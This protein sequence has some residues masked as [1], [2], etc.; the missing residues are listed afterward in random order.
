MLVPRYV[1]AGI[2]TEVCIFGL[3][4]GNGLLGVPFVISLEIVG[5]VF[6][7]LSCGRDN[8]YSALRFIVK[9]AVVV[10]N[11]WPLR[12]GTGLEESFVSMASLAVLVTGVIGFVASPPIELRTELRNY[13]DS[14]AK[15]YRH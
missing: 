7:N 15:S 13:I 3:V 2:G 6:S 1:P 5:S 12:S 10:A 8:S 14:L 11:T 4:D 9:P